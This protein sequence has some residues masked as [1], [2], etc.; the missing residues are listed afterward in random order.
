MKETTTMDGGRAGR[1]R[2]PDERIEMMV[3]KDDVERPW[4]SM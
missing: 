4:V 3:Q 2:P 1:Y